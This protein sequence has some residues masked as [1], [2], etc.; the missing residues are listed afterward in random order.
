MSRGLLW[1]QSEEPSPQ[2]LCLVSVMASYTCFIR[3]TFTSSTTNVSTSSGS[4]KGLSKTEPTPGFTS[5]FYLRKDTSEIWK[6]KVKK[7]PLKT[8]LQ[9][10]FLINWFCNDDQPVYRNKDWAILFIFISSTFIIII[11][12][13]VLQIYSPTPL[14]Y[15]SHHLPI[16]SNSVTTLSNFPSQSMCELLRWLTF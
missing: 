10:I 14:S 3:A 15:H 11:I 6:Y 2:N 1:I 5:N 16:Q 7:F 8:E 9:L 4:T 12:Y 13:S